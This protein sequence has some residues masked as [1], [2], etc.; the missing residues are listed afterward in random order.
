[1]LLKKYFFLLFC[2]ILTLK[3]SAQDESN[4]TVLRAKGAPVI[5]NSDTLFYLY[6]N[7]GSFTPFE[8]AKAVVDRITKLAEDVTLE[9]D[10]IKA[11]ETDLATEVIYKDLILFT[12]TDVE[13]SY[14]NADRN[15]LAAEYI[16]S[17]KSSVSKLNEELNLQTLFINIGILS[18]IIGLLWALIY[19]VNKLFKILRRK[20]ISLKETK[21]KGINIRD[22]QLVSPERQVTFLFGFL[23]VFR[24]LLIVLLIYI[25]LPFLFS[26]FPASKPIAETLFKYVFD[27][28][29]SILLAIINFIPNLLTILVIYFVTTYIVK[30]FKFLAR[31]VNDGN[32]KITNFYPDWAMPTFNIVRGLLYIF[33]F[34]VIWPY[35]PGSGSPVFQGVSVLLGVLIS[36]GSSSAISNMVAGLVITY[37]RPFRIGDR[38]KVGDVLG[39]VI[40]KNLLVTRVLT[41]KN[42]E[43]TIPN[44]SILSSY[45]INYSNAAREN[46]GLVLHT[47]VTIGYD[48]PWKKV[49]ELLINAATKTE[50][51][52]K[53]P[54]PFVLQTSLDDF[55]VSYQLNAYT[56]S[57]NRMARIYSDIHQNIQDAFNEAGV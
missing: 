1:M 41:N 47:T 21:L 22:Y 12:I 25:S 29:K 3:L 32:L 15:E 4:P 13:A 43:I 37:M 5:L 14:S 35:L 49:H 11:K 46:N 52:Q 6:T 34:I 26:V 24:I 54:S 17:I 38:V 8:R 10:S 44:S 36:F 48:V 23:K 53:K 28:F 39:D 18:L 20:L 19:G 16:T 30:F 42:E 9:L 55:Y 2:L 40:E 33:M 50:H 31:E 7:Q 51:I 27:P 56:K 57:T 45:T